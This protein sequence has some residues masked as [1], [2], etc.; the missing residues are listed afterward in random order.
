MDRM[1]LRGE[2]V[3][4][5]SSVQPS[6]ASLY[7]EAMERFVAWASRVG[8]LTATLRQ[9]DAALA[10]YADVLFF[11]IGDGIDSFVRAIYGYNYF[12]SK[13]S[14]PLTHFPRAQR[15]LKGWRKREPGHSR[16]GAPFEVVCKMA[17]ELI[18][19]GNHVLAC[20][21]LVH[22]DT[23]CRPN[24]FLHIRKRDVFPP[25][26]ENLG[27]ADAWVLQIRPPE[28]LIP[29]KVGEFDDTV[30]IDGNSS[31]AAKEAI[32]FV[33]SRTQSDADFLFPFDLNFF[34]VAIK[35]ISKKLCL[36]KMLLCPHAMRHGGASTDALRGRRSLLS[37]QKRGRWASINS[38]KRYEKAGVLLKQ[39]R[40]APA[41]MKRK[42]SQFEREFISNLK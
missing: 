30:L 29:T 35:R 22:H 20:A 41:G 33:Y 17:S 2:N 5:N 25:S 18:L 21:L 1:N 6:T 24:E 7:L 34:G 32:R 19:E 37:I 15:A 8:L 12:H 27:L 3:L 28:D 11:D 9:I 13:K 40:Y 31:S 23:Y 42:A 14:K 36:Q 38:L 39:W 4:E 26:P 16:P 10:R